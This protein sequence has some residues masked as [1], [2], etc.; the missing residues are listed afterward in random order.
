MKPTGTGRILLWSGGSL[1][2]GHSGEPTDFHSHHAV[3]ISLSLAGDCLRFRLPGGNWTNYS[4]AIVAAN[5]PHAFEARGA[6]VAMIFV[7][8]ESREGR[9]LQKLCLVDGIRR[10]EDVPIEDDRLEPEIAHLVA[11]YKSVAGDAD[12]IS[13]AR[14][15]IG[16]LASTQ[17]GAEID[18]DRRIQRAVER[19]RER[20]GETIF[21]SDIAAAAFL[22]PDRFRHLFVEETGMRFRPF[23]LWLR[24]EIALAAFAANKSLTE[25]AHAGGFADSAHFSRT[26]RRMFGIAPSSFQRE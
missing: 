7:E 22:S 3:Q 19:M 20:I 1:W 6:F 18:L 25:A 5:H 14:L 26:F 21:L 16:R 24:V 4:G 10:I 12:L 15:I 2:I 11:C 23:V 17:L 13:A 8:P 9:V